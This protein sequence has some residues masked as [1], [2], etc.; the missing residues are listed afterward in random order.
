MG[1]IGAKMTRYR[2][3]WTQ[4]IEE[5]YLGEA[6]KPKDKKVID[7]FYKEDS[8]VGNL[9]STDG[10]SLEKHGMGGQ[11]I[12]AWLNGKIAITAVSDVKSTEAILNYMKKSI[13]KGNFDPKSYKK[14]F[15]EVEEARTYLDRE[16]ERKKK[17][18]GKIPQSQ[19]KSRWG[20][21]GYGKGEEAE[22]DEAVN[23]KKL[24]KE[25]EDNEDK[26]NHTENYL[27][28]AKAFGT[29][30][31]VKKVQEI[32]KRNKKQG[33]TSK[34]DMD[35][36]YKNINP[37]YDKIRNEE[38][39]IDEGKYKLTDDKGKIIATYDSDGKARKAMDYF[40]RSGKHKNLTVV[41]EGVEIEE[42]KAAT[43]YD[44]YH[45]DFSSAMQHA[46][47]HAKKKGFVVDPKEIDDKVATGPKKPSSGKTNRYAL[48]AG[49]KT[50]HIQVANLDNKKYELNMYI[51][52]VEL[53]EKGTAYPATVDT[54]RK[55]VKDKQHQTVMFDKGQALVD[56][57]TASA[58]LAVYDAM[59]KPDIKKKFENMIKSKEGFIKTQAF[60]MK[61]IK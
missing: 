34:S 23:L 36:M 59:K 50:V 17:K 33:H 57:F 40:I 46:Y 12:A 13:P 51:E 60:A 20:S 22:V 44:L 3:S 8:L 27:L 37:Y 11:T 28:L 54:L 21:G 42:K 56:T 55:I 47:A 19:K 10:K 18:S 53:T 7:A 2:K 1:Q 35:W 31:E 29:S 52:G 43:G 45:K 49:R 38:V 14:F 48:K 15:E 61:M 9:L 30:A 6:L 58:M 24:K 39:E 26:N 25:Y 41:K 4:V 16:D 5:V 32:M